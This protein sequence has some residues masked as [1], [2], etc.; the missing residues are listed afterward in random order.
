[1]KKR[2]FKI[3]VT[4]LIS[5]TFITLL[6]LTLLLEPSIQI[7]GYA[8]LDKNK[9]SMIDDTLSI[10]YPDGNGTIAN[11]VSYNNR[12]IVR[13]ENLPKHVANA[14]IAIEDKRFYSHNGVD[15]LR[16]MGAMKNNLVSGGFKE[17]ASTITQ[18]LV[19]NT[20]LKNDKTLKR[21]VQEIRIAKSIERN[22]DK[23]KILENYLNILYFGSNQYGIENASK[24]FFNKGAS[25]LSLSESALLA[26]IIN[27]P[28][29]YSPMK[30]PQKALARRNLVLKRMREQK[31]ISDNEYVN[32]S[33][34]DLNITLRK[35][36]VN[37][38]ADA[39]IMQTSEVLRCDKNDLFATGVK[40]ISCCDKELQEYVEELIEQNAVENTFTHVI[41]SNNKTAEILVDASN[42]PFSLAS[43]RRQPG[44]TIKPFLSYVPA[45]EQKKVY[46]CTPI[47]DEKSTFNDWTPN[48]FN[49][50]YFGWVSVKDSLVNSLNVPAVKLLDLVGVENAKFIAEKF[51]FSFNPSDNSLA[52]A[53]GGMTNGVT[54]Y[55]LNNAYLSLANNGFSTKG[56]YVK[57]IYDNNK[58]IY[59]NN[60]THSTRAVREETAYLITDCLLECAQNGTAKQIKFAGKNIAAKTGTVGNKEG[61]LDAYCIAYSPNFTVS[62]HVSAMDGVMENSISG[63]NLP[64]LLARKIF[65]KLNDN[66]N[67]KIPSGIKFADIDAHKWKNERKVALAGNSLLPIQRKNVIFDVANMPKRYSETKTNHVTNKTILDDFNNFEIIDRLIN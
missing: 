1:M 45:F 38:Y 65:E 50:R 63:G 53:L 19:K 49:D 31:F 8:E 11:D 40:I 56:R 48:N 23:D 5:L 51:G 55:E 17:G 33:N 43:Y 41:I 6:F 15:Y 37:Q 13:L 24:Y 9:L 44:S 2:I 62:V 47:L 60:L 20:H 66:D 57:A 26:G 29:L 64:T 61:N 34:T 12:K 28:S 36:M 35:N 54:L 22:Y 16:I 32:S 39:C 59:V 4:T 25:E 30:S 3:A 46:S 14:F 18:Q 67:F 42:C 52:L 10:H 58:A 7:N 21:K 27:N